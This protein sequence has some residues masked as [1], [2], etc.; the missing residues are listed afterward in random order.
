M[1]RTPSI[2]YVDREQ[3]LLVKNL[4]DANARFTTSAYYALQEMRKRCDMQVRHLG[5]RNDDSTILA[6]YTGDIFAEGE[7]AILKMLNKYA[8]ASPAGR[9]MQHQLGIGPVIAA[10]FLAH[11][12]IE[13]APTAGHIW[14]FA[15]LN[16]AQEWNKGEKRP[17]CAAMKQ[18]VFHAGECFKRVSGKPDALYAQLYKSRKAL[19]VERNNLGYNTER[20]KTY[21]TTSA[22][23]RK[24]LKLG[25]LPDGNL[26]RQACNFAVKIFLSHLH[27]V[28]YWCRYKKVP[29][30]P[31]G[32][33]ILGHAHEIKIPDLDMFPGLEG[34]YYGSYSAAAE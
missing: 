18:L 8:L 33:A 1:K 6:K 30:K 15:G 20:A 2:P 3:L 21:T 24:V 16:P 19:L 14:S 17:Y 11:I 22:D 31:F 28:M 12:D 23:V 5:D 9:W 13:K 29:P 26:D 34:A 27:V 25:K 32:I 10:G 4:T 7:A